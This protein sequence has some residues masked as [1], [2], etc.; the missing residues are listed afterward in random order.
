MRLTGSRCRC[1]ACGD[2]FNSVSVFDRHRVST[3]FGEP[4]RRC[5]AAAEMAARGWS[6]NAAGFW[7]AETRSE[8]ATRSVASHVKA[9]IPSK[10]V[11][12]GGAD[13]IGANSRKATA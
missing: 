12:E 3:R 2:C 6:R 13:E 4:S 7:I 10:V 8:R 5:L 1:T 11:P 9:A